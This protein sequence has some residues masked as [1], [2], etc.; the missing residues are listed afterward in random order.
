[1]V[2]RN[3][4]LGIKGE[5]AAGRANWSAALFQLDQTNLGMIDPA[6]PFDEGNACEGWCYLA[7]GKVRT[8][9]VDLGVQGEL[10]SRWT[11]AA[12][13]SWFNSA[14]A[15]GEDDGQRYVPYMPRHN[16]RFAT[17]YRPGDGRWTV[18]GT[19]RAQN[20]VYTDATNYRA[21]QGSLVVVGLS[22]GYAL[23]PATSLTA[24]IDNV[25]DRRYYMELS[26]VNF[27]HYGEPRRFTLMLRHR[28]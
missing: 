11:L 18:G 19:L 28:F 8:R 27:V 22:T 23:T 7:A 17:L 12:N 20:G 26:S 1:M 24:L 9:G 6:T 16:L 2:G 5:L 10:T 14:H 3:F 21:R 25:F 4:E 15:A 13:Y